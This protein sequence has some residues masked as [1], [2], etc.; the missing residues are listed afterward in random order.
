M[1]VLI[2]GFPGTGKTAIAAELKRRGHRAYDPEVMRGHTHVEDR[3]TGERVHPP[4]PVPSGWY[5][6]TG[7]HTWDAVK[8][9][10]L[11]G[12]SAAD[13]GADDIF[14][15]GF[16]HNVG[17]F[18]DLFDHVFMLTLDDTDLEQRLLS[19]S[20]ALIGRTPTERSDIMRLRGEFE[21][22]MVA[23]GAHPLG[24]HAAPHQLVDQ[25]L[26]TLGA[27]S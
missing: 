27:R 23:R 21:R 5:D 14:V 3:A 17:D 15:C 8:L 4:K 25:I 10:E 24:S 1:N 9:R 16:A 12:S 19:R 11:L 13:A 18:W 22:R 26:T 20:N 7:A 6:T 2:T